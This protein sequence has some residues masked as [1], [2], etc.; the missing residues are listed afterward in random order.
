MDY[1]PQNTKMSGCT[2][3]LT[4]NSPLRTTLI[5]EATGQAV[6]N[7]DTPRKLAPDVT[8]IRKLDSPTQPPHHWDDGGDDGDFSEGIADRKGAFREVEGAKPDTPPELPETSDEIARI[9]WKFISS[10]KIVFR[11][12]S[13]TQKEFLPPAGKLRGYVISP[14][15]LCRPN[16]NSFLIP[17]VSHLLDQMAFSTDGRW[18]RWG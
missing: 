18:V 13:T 14:C 1:S 10:D 6:Y 2:F 9:Y 8:K 16:L 12:R 11:G 4:R 15:M 3:L 7:V 17:G 5:D